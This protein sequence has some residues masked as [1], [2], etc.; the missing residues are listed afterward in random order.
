MPTIFAIGQ[1]KGYQGYSTTTQAIGLGS[2]TF[3]VNASD[4]AYSVGAR[5]RVA[6]DANN[7]MEGTV[8]SYI[9]TVLTANFDSA[10]GSGTYSNWYLN[11][12]GMPGSGSGHTIQD[13]GAPLPQRAALNFLGSAVTATDDSVNNRTNIAISGGSGGGAFGFALYVNGD[14]IDAGMTV[15]A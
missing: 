14:L 10:Q 4:L 11:I 9:G 2:K 5:I 6:T 7:W 12:A 8:T 1:A 15:N 13:E 3:V